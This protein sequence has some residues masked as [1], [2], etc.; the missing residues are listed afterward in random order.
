MSSSQPPQN[1]NADSQGKSA[2]KPFSLSLGGGNSTATT[3]TT[4]VNGQPKKT[5]F[6]LQGPTRSTDSPNRTLARRPHHLHDDEDS[7]EEAPPVHEAVTGFDTLTG[8]AIPANKPAEK[9]ELVIPVAGNN[10]W[11]DR[12]GVNLRKSKGKNLLPKEVQAIQEAQKRGE[13]AGENVETERPSMAYGLTFAQ[14]DSEQVGVQPDNDR[15][16]LDAPEPAA[17]AAAAA[18]AAVAEERKPLTQDEIALQALIRETN[19]EPERRSDLVIESANRDDGDERAGGRYDETT[20][21][22]ADIASRP[23]SASL[24]QYNAIPVE[25][26]GAA[27]LRGMGWKEGQAVG[28][29]KY[30]GASGNQD[31]KPRIPE[32][33]P[34]F[35]GI[36]AKDAS[37]GKGAEAE[38]GAW[39][40]AAMRKGSRKAGKE[41]ESN[42]EGVYM[43]IMMR[44][45]KTGEFITEEELAAQ[46]KDVKKRGDD[47]D[48]KE[49]RDRNLEKSGRDRDRDHRD[50]DS[51]RRDYDDDDSDRYDRRRTGSSRRDRSLSASDRHSR[52]RKYGDEDSDSRDDR[53]YRDRDSRRDRDR[54]GNGDRDRERD[55]DRDRDRDRSRRYRDDDRYSSSRHSSSHTSSRHRDR[56]RERD[57]DRD[58]HRRRR[59]DDR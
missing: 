10:N 6:N 53:Y 7:D 17:A 33:R 4:P 49:R 36:G 35:L 37:G 8:T 9:R 44:N 19:G 47:D 3:T 27:L 34:G 39:G 16:M 11:R 25:E 56:D 23:E 42:T 58:S 15:P 22:R 43:P 20:S 52:R 38:L 55:R 5:A 45:T 1:G 30:G 24:D 48:W 13:V 46:R 21:F 31:N 40:K 32:R 26:F 29:G 2:A 12:P 41:G 57:S 14:R 54:N 50:R 18:A 28:R 51:R 59:D